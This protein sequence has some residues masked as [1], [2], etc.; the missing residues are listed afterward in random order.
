MLDYAWII[1]LLP[2]ASFFLILFFGKRLPR[3][4]SELGIAAVGLA[5]VLAIV[6]NVN[7]W[8]HVDDAEHEAE[9]HTEEVSEEEEGHAA[10]AR[11]PASR[12]PPPRRASSRSRARRRS[13]PRRRKRPTSPSSR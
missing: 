12:P 13:T 11:P 7:W 9:T 1:P 5:F 6:V 10:R 3:K 2:A 4:G 8:S